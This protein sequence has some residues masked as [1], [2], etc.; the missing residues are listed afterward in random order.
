MI[1]LRT[2]ALDF[3]RKVQVW[4]EMPGGI[5]GVQVVLSAGE[6]VTLNQLLENYQRQG[7]TAQLETQARHWLIGYREAESFSP[8]LTAV[9]RQELD[10]VIDHL[11]AR[12]VPVSH[13]RRLLA[14][15]QFRKVYLVLAGM[16]L[17]FL[18]AWGI[19]AI[20]SATHPA[21]PV[22]QGAKVQQNPP[23]R[24]VPAGTTALQDF[25]TDW[26]PW[27]QLPVSQQNP[28]TGAPALLYMEQ[29]G[30]YVSQEWMIPES[31]PAWS[32]D[33]GGNVQNV[34]VEGSHALITDMD[35]NPYVVGIGQPFVFSQ[36]PGTV[37]SIGPASDV[38]AIPEPHAIAIRQHL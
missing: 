32:P 5:A 15:A 30:Y 24:Q 26:G 16:A 28:Q 38:R 2:P 4:Q 29:G 17:I 3:L 13:N 23:A 12:P 35:G 31:S 37:L 19:S 21:N 25:K 20:W 6:E 18:C 7:A 33:L 34:D 8:T 10:N 14:G 22:P 36:N 9:Q 1:P 11:P 27:K